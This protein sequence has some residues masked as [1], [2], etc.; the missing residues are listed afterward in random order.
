[1]PPPGFQ[2]GAQNIQPPRT[3]LV[4]LSGDEDSILGRMKQK[5]R[6][7]VRL[8]QRHG[9][10]VRSSADLEIFHQLIQVTGERDRFGVHSKEY[11][12]RRLSSFSFLRDCVNYSWQK[13][14]R[15]R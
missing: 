6:Y 10:L 12:R 1:M 9:V 7:N 3:L 14:M 2:M 15:N 13:W 5:T 4:D 8:A 11:Y